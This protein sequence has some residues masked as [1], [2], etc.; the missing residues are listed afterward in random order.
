MSALSVLR[1]D[2]DLAEKGIATA[3]SLFAIYVAGFG[4]FDNVLVSGITVWL[5]AIYAFAAWRPKSGRQGMLAVHAVLILVMSLLVW[6]WADLN[7]RQQEFIVSIRNYEHVMAWL[8]FVLVTYATWRFFG[9]PMVLVIGAAAAYALLP[10]GIGGGETWTRISE[11][12]W[13]SSDGTFGRPVEVVGRTVL[14]YLVLGSILQVAGAGDVLMRV[15]YALTGRIPGGPAHATIVS[16]AMFGMMS[17]ATVANVVSSGIFTIPVIKKTGFS[18]KFAGGV[19]A[20]S[21]AGGQFTPPVMGA[22][23]FLMA[24]LTG[25]PYLQIALAA[26]LPALMFYASLS[27]IVTIEAKRLGITSVPAEARVRLTRRDAYESLALITPLLV[28]VGIM[29]LGRTAQLAGAVAALSAFALCLVI[30]P[31]FRS[32]RRWLDVLLDAGRG[33]CTL[34]M[35]VAAIGFVIGIVNMTGIGIWFAELVMALTGQSLVLALVMVMCAS[36]VLGM[37]VPTGAAY[38]IIAIVLGP[39]LSTL[40][41]PLIAVHLFILYFGVMSDVTPPVALAAYAAAPIAGAGPMETGFAAV[42]LA[43]AGFIIPFVFVL[44]PDILLVVDGASATGVLWALAAFA[45]ATWGLGTGLVGWDR[46]LLPMWERV[47]RV[48]TGLA[49]LSTDWWLALTAA[50]ALCLLTFMQ[51]SRSLTVAVQKQP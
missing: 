8:G 49:C 38:L 35:V 46:A 20:A 17:G 4:F 1:R 9:L 25:I 42:R 28:I 45:A 39:A 36:L 21:S 50:A 12:V 33:A 14:I 15:A 48:L 19:E 27:A 11:N 26:T 32:P 30:Y 13:Y 3:M 10:A 24:D 43:S 5:A 44:H 34:M 22:V 2:L 41:A 7:F 51:R 37:G 16:S 47:L 18:A 29:I 40:G 31:S 6:A 23:A